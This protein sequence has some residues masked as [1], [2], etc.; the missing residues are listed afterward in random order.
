MIKPR[1]LFN[2]DIAINDIKIAKVDSAF[3][4][5]YFEFAK[6]EC[7][8]N[9]INYPLPGYHTIHINRLALNSKDS[10]L[11]IDSLKV[12]PQLGKLEL[13]RKLGHQADHISAVAPAITLTGIDFKQLMQQKLIA[14]ELNINNAVVYVFRDRRLIQANER[15][16]NVCRLFKNKFHSMYI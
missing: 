13:G 2:A 14:N 3:S 9:D 16:A 12:I 6:V 4:L 7:V 8:L 5:K 11:K 15:S 10:I 1:P